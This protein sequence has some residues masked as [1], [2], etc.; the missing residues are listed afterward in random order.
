M[1]EINRVHQQDS[2]LELLRNRINWI[3]DYRT[4]ICE[5]RPPWMDETV[6]DRLQTAHHELTGMYWNPM[7]AT[8]QVEDWK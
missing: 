8:S 7:T 3:Y 5:Y 4:G 1:D 2:Q 6:E